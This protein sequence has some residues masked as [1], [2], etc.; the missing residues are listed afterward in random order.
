M[1]F[2]DIPS[3]QTPRIA[4]PML[5]HGR[6]LDDLS[7]ARPLDRPPSSTIRAHEPERS[8]SQ[9]H[10]FAGSW[11]TSAPRAKCRIGLRGAQRVRAAR[12]GK[13]TLQIAEQTCGGL[14][15]FD[16]D[17]WRKRVKR[18]RR[19]AG[20][21]HTIPLARTR[22]PQN[23]SPSGKHQRKRIGL[24]QM[25]PQYCAS[26]A[27]FLPSKGTRSP[28]AP[29]KI[30]DHGRASGNF[31]TPRHKEP[32]PRCYAGRAPSSVSGNEI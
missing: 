16:R 5:S 32:L 21:V 23:P 17:I 1:A 15:E 11:G 31:V 14:G 3:I 30:A 9:H 12:I 22:H 28:T 24:F 25:R 4:R 26:S 29:L 10:A 7:D 20:Q 2:P 18:L 13:D 19:Q 27:V 8:T 6:P